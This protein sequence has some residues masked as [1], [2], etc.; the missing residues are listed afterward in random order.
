[1]VE[2]KLTIKPMSQPNLFLR[3]YSKLVDI[4][5]SK[6]GLIWGVGDFIDRLVYV[7]N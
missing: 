3:G 7:R 2:R 6:G 1:M 5:Q 4:V